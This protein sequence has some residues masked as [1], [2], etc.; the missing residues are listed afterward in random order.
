MNNDFERLVYLLAEKGVLDDDDMVYLYDKA[1][2]LDDW[3]ERKGG[4][5]E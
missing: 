5:A 2:T 1:M 4:E 3:R